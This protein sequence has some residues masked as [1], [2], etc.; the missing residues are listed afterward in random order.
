MYMRCT[1]AVSFLVRNVARL[2]RAFISCAYTVFGLRVW[3]CFEVV[4]F[5]ER[6]HQCKTFCR[7][8]F[9]RSYQNALKKKA[10]EVMNPVSM[11]IALIP[12][13]QGLS[14][15][16][17]VRIMKKVNLETVVETYYKEC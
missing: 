15:K 13:Q 4:L 17:L 12:S 10:M 5:A 3:F 14:V 9:L 2:S 11:Q 7:E 16:G 8:N 6:Q 1:S